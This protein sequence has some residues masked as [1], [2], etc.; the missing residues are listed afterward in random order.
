MRMR[1]GIILISLCAM[2]LFSA[3]GS[4]PS[5]DSIRD[6]NVTERIESNEEA[7][8]NENNL[9]K[10]D[11]SKEIID[12]GLF[13]KDGFQ[14]YDLSWNS[15]LK[16]AES[17]LGA[18]SKD[19]DTMHDDDTEIYVYPDKMPLLEKEA[20]IS[21]EYVNKRLTA[22]VFDI[23]HETKEETESYT[24]ELL[25]EVK[26]LYGE[27]SG[28]M[29]VDEK[30]NITYWQ[31]NVEDNITSLQVA[32]DTEKQCTVVT[33]LCEPQNEKMETTIS[34]KDFKDRDYYRYAQ[35]PWNTPK[36]TFDEMLGEDT[37]ELYQE[38]ETVKIYRVL[39]S[40][41]LLETGEE[42]II[43]LEFKDDKLQ[44][45]NLIMEEPDETVRNEKY[46]KVKEELRKL[47]G[48][49]DSEDSMEGMKMVK[50]LSE[51]DGEKTT[52]QVG[53]DERGIVRIVLAIIQ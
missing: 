40:V 20:E 28:S 50:W 30:L 39:E 35:I 1:F 14:F 13:K 45:M 25:S 18:L 12:I 41:K 53:N 17:Y 51:K 9:G 44:M 27:S 52:V 7:P 48:E 10:S 6:E 43:E 11:S 38:F 23:M 47:Y 8:V 49:A 33:L 29:E 42:V 15:G 16:E 26:Q 21:L 4:E 34:F 31:E 2:N 36:E 32:E 3:C 22:V 24:T 46:A 5:Y 19:S 37:M